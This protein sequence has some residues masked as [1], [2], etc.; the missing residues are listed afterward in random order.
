L[1]GAHGTS[2]YLNFDK[3]LVIA[4][5]ATRPGGNTP[6]TL[7]LLEQFWLAAERAMMRLERRKQ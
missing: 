7:A 3:R 1:L 5:Y 2:L 6:A 4:M